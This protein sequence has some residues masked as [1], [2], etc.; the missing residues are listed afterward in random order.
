MANIRL[1]AES[2][3]LENYAVETQNFA[4]SGALARITDDTGSIKTTLGNGVTAGNYSIDIAYFDESDGQSSME[5]WINGTRQDSWKFDNSPGGTRASSSNR[6][7]RRVPVD[8][9]LKAGDTIE[10]RGTLDAGEVARVDYIELIPKGTT[11]PTPTPANRVPVAGNDSATT[12]AGTP[13]II[14]VMGNDSDPDGDSL[15]IAGVSGAANGTVSSNTNGT[16]TYTPKDGFSGNDSFSYSISDGKGGSATATVGVV[17][18][19]APS[20]SITSNSATSGSAATSSSTAS[21]VRIEAESMTLVGYQKESASFASGGQL[22]RVPNEGGK[23]TATTQFTGA[24]GT[25]DLKVVYHDESDGKSTLKITAGTAF[26]TSFVFDEN[27]GDSRAS[28]GNRRERTFSGIQLKANDT[29]QLEGFLNVGEVARVDYIELIPQGGTGG[30]TTPPAPTNKA[31]VA[32]NDSATTQAGTPVAIN[33]LSNDSDPD[34]DSLSISGVSSA[35]NGTVSS[36]TNGT[37]TYTPKAGF[38]GNDS[39]SYSVSDGKGGSAT[40]TVG[41]AV[42]PAPATGGTG[43]GSTGGGTASVV[44]IEAESMTLV[45]YQKESASF[46]SGGQLIRVPNEGGKSTATTQFTGV[47]GT[48]DLKVVYHDENDGKSTLKITAGTAFS[49]S[50]VFDENTGDSRASSGNRRERTFSDV[51]LN[52]NDTIQLEGF[53]NVGEVARVD[54]IELIPKGG[55]TTT[56]TPVNRAP[57]AGND[58]ATT[59]AGTPVAINVLSNDS[60][61]DGDLLSIAGVSGAANGT[62]SSN[63]NGTLTYT[64]KAGFSGN[65]SFSYSISDGKGGSATATVGVAVNPAPATGG[66]GTG[67]TGSGTASVVRIEAESMTL[68]GYQ[69]ESASFASGGQLIRVPNEGGK[70]TATTQ[71]T[72]VSGTYDL[73]VVYHDENDGKSTLK[74][75]AGTAFSTS[76][77]F[78]ENTGD[79]RASSGNRRERTFSDVQL[80]A[81]DTIQLEGFLN[82]GEVARVDYIELIPKGGTTT[83][84]DSGSGGSG[85]GDTPS[86]NSTAGGVILNL[87]AGVGLSPEFGAL[88][89]PRLIPLGDSITAGQ[90]SSGAVPG[91]YRMQLEDR[92]I[93]DGLSID[94]VGSQRNGGSDLADKDHA[95]FPG[96]TIS[97]TTEWVRNGN[98]SQYPADGILLMIGT[99]DANGGASGTAMR[100]RLSTLID[101][102]SKAAPAAY[103][104]VSSI[105]P[106]DAP[107]GTQAKRDNINDYNSR[108]PQLVSDKV[109]AGKKVFFVNAGGSLDVGD[110][111]GDN[112]YTTDFDDGLHPTAAGYDKLGDAWYKE[113][114][115]PKSLSGSKLVGTE[116]DDWLIG[117]SGNNVIEGGNGRDELLG[118][119]GADIFVYKDPT[120]G[121]DKIVDFSSN[122]IL[123]ISAAGFGGGLSAGMTLDSSSFISGSNPSATSN[124]ATFLYNTSSKMLS[125]D[126]DGT[127]GASAFEIATFTNGFSLQ[128]NQIDIV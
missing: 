128:S 32:G 43:T 117:N 11:T 72:G 17:V 13:I 87:D 70:S 108:I 79:S 18:N 15:S 96:R 105:P 1:E 64:P 114:F 37:L 14:N 61:P 46:A 81:N 20:T 115:N 119:G 106:V 101:E 55:T 86:G 25:Y 99:N 124:K 104:Y 58:S 97:Q 123:Q 82:V 35:A 68:V 6:V 63:A 118:G 74:I 44:R 2:L 77:V 54:Y 62:V 22:I 33:V 127:G 29:I 121:K 80:K 85:G 48:Y 45:G 50:F 28:S 120:H 98:L 51:Q 126:R 88:K 49:T 59:Q 103:I 94:F 53:L 100:D 93:A 26:S 83:N 116:H 102:I 69:K 78:D 56:P 66:T 65:D 112:S 24:A 47:S 75:T 84:P 19:P 30:T 12:Q 92:A 67:S 89:M 5:L 8:I 31:P 57:V 76:F 91:G 21:V 3:T 23:S 111:N 7:V 10:L 73:K 71:F 41:V 39:F 113:V 60:D 34:G 122:D 38:S 95:G 110:I 27:T 109:A 42:N 125:F 36:N 4:S 16:L 52:T 40:A 9:A 90:H 107:R